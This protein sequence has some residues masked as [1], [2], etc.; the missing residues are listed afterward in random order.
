MLASLK[1]QVEEVR[2]ID[3]LGEQKFHEV[4]KK[5][6]EPLTDTI[7]V[8]SRDTTKT[9]TET[10]CRNNGALKTLN[11]KLLEKLNVMGIKAPYLLSPLSKLTN[12]EK[13]NQFTLVKGPTSTRVND[14]LIKK[15]TPVTLYNILLAFSDTDEN[16]YYKAIL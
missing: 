3:K 1:N 10:F 6:F 12:I 14:L 5:L 15:T 4:M 13:T 11:D 2:L 9:M 8:I 16:S 7:K